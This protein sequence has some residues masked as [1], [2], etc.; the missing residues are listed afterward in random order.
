[1]NDLSL[2]ERLG[3]IGKAPRWAVA[4]KFESESAQTFIK[5]I[6]IQIGRT[7]AVTPVARLE[8]VNIGGVIV[9]NATLHNFD[10]IEKKDIRVGDNVLIERA[11]DV[12]PHVIEVIKQ[13]KKKRS[14]PFVIP[15]KCPICNSNIISDPD[16]VVIR[17]SGIYKCEAQI[18]GRLKHFV[19]RSALDIDGLGDKQINLLY[20]N[21]IISKYSDIYDLKNKKSLITNLDGW[22]DLSFDNLIKA[23]DNKKNISLITSA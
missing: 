11:G 18:I 13:N 4:H 9:S 8:P 20:K 6:D 3:Y 14:K 17:C 2:Q 22:G 23:V 16:E 12:I 10:E 7:G 21:K 1:M 19:S 15:I 5:Q